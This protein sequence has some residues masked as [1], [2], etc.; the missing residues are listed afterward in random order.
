[1]EPEKTEKKKLNRLVILGNGF[2]LSL[3][4]KTSYKDFLYSYLKNIVNKLYSNEPFE[5]RKI[6]FNSNYITYNGG[7]NYPKP[8]LPESV[9][10]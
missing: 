1:M 4:M 2:D 5:G 6:E 10:R 8:D 7:V 3:G 9:S